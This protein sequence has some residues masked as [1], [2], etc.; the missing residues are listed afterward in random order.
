V[1]VDLCITTFATLSTGEK[2]QK[3]GHLQHRLQALRRNQR[4]LARRQHSSR[5]R[6][7][8]VATLHNEA[9]QARVRFAAVWEMG[10]DQP[11]AFP[12]RT[13]RRPS[14]AVDMAVELLDL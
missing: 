9:N 7:R 6:K 14:A 12:V 2:I 8:K 10:S 13:S 11:G 4:R 5:R 1:G 3:P